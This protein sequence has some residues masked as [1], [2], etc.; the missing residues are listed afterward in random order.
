MP[1]KAPF[2]KYMDEYLERLRNRSPA[3]R[4]MYRKWLLEL[5]GTARSVGLTRT[6]TG[7]ELEEIEMLLEARTFRMDGVPRANTTVRNEVGLLN[8]YLKHVGN[9]SLD[10][11]LEV[12]EVRKPPDTKAYRRW[13]SLEDV[14]ALRATARHL[15]DHVALMSMQL[16]LDAY[17]RVSEIASLDLVDAQGTTI[18]VRR[19][20]G[21]KDRLVEITE[22]TRLDLDLFISGPRAD[23]VRGEHHPRLLVHR[24]RGRLSGYSTHSIGHRVRMVGRACSPPIAVSPH[25]LRRTGA[26]LTYVSNPTDRT[27]RDLQAALGHSTAEQTRE[28]IGSAVVDQ[29]R[30]IAARD[31]YLE[32]MY[33]EEFSQSGPC[34]Y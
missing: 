12:G 8:R 15:G 11:A 32:K 33:P 16:A 25:D 20:K 4:S 13:K 14:I 24:A 18:Q 5:E 30:T 9:Y 10:R 2:R 26:Q 31:R 19:G 6:P 23:R 34:R 29:R 7:W 27:V 17:L 22:R 3:T 1:R 21:R 28:Y